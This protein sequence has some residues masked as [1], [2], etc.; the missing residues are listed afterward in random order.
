MQKYA[1]ILILTFW[2]PIA[3]AKTG[4]AQKEIEGWV[5]EANE[6]VFL[7][8]NDTQKIELK[9]IRPLLKKGDRAKVKYTVI[10]EQVTL[11]KAKQQPGEVPLF[12][13]MIID[14]R[15]FYPALS[16]P[17]HQNRPTDQNF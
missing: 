2:T 4:K 3:L 10:T 5:Q 11:E 1:W 9:Q 17:Q 16:E 6:E 15:A 7:L 8:Q 13:D 12:K 14:D